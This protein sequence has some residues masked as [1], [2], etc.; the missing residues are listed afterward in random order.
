MKIEETIK[1][2]FDELEEQMKAMAAIP[3]EDVAHY[4][5]SDWRQWATSALHLL[6]S[7]FGL[8]SDHYRNFRDLYQ[9]AR[10]DEYSI[11]ALRGVFL[12][13][14]DDYCGGYLFSSRASCLAILSRLPRRP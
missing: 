2:R 11:G 6:Q 14:K 1:K 8:T 13:A 3:D 5:I 7:V 4:D 9:V 12:A 10:S